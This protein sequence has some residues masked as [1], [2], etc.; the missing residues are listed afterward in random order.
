MNDNRDLG[1]TLATIRTEHDPNSTLVV[2]IV[3]LQTI[4]GDASY[5]HVYTLPVM[6]A[7]N[8]QLLNQVTA[9][10]VLFSPPSARRSKIH[11]YDLDS[12][13]NYCYRILRALLNVFFTFQEG[14]AL[15]AYEADI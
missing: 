2:R 6:K 14:P 11:Y 12:A 5:L 10:T 13:T 1:L 9:V 15:E 4:G 7:G 3:D 8:A